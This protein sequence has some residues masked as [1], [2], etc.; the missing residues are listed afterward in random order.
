MSR[1]QK[2]KPRKRNSAKE[3]DVHYSNLFD[4]NVNFKERVIYLNDDIDNSSLELFLKTF[5]ELERGQNPGPIRIEISSYGGDVYEML[6][7]IDRIR[8]SPCHIVTRGF[9]KIMSA[10]TFILA[11]GDERFMGAHS[12]M[13]MHEMSDIMKGKMGDIK[14]EFKHSESL[15]EQMYQMYEQFSEGKTKA[16]AFKKLCTGKDH[17]LDAETALK[18]GLIDKII[19]QENSAS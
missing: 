17:Y 16:S 8:S 4:N 1:K 5:D 13:M 7:I 6:G 2:S 10:A 19:R 3:L 11:A 14:N 12:W 15:E 18:L 9:G